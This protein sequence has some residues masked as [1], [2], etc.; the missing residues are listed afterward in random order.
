MTVKEDST[1]TSAHA[2][3]HTHPLHFSN[4]YTEM[5]N[6]VFYSHYNLTSTDS[7]TH[8]DRRSWG[9]ELLSFTLVVNP[10]YLVS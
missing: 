3:T 8:D 10:L 2:H 5:I 6:G 7:H 9:F 1:V 4:T